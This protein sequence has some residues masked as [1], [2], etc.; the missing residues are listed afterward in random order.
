MKVGEIYYWVTDKAVGYS[1]RPKYH[2][3]ICEADWEE[4]N[5]FLFI[6]KTNYNGDYAISNINYNF[7]PLPI[8]YVGG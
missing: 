1:T 4:E 6:S 3:F 5:T 2:V 8:S 7:L